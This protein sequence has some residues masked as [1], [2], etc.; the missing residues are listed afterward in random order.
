MRFQLG[1]L[2]IVGV[3]TVIGIRDVFAQQRQV[4]PVTITYRST[5]ATMT[6]WSADLTNPGVT[7]PFGAASAPNQGSN[8]I[9]RDTAGQKPPPAASTMGTSFSPGFSRTP[10]IPESSSGNS[11][12]P[13]NQQLQ[14]PSGGFQLTHA[15]F[16]Q[17]ATMAPNNYFGPEFQNWSNLQMRSGNLD[18]FESFN[19]FR[20][21]D[22]GAYYSPNTY[23]G[24]ENN[25]WSN[26]S[27]GVVTPNDLG[28]W[29]YRP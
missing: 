8:P 5:S 17:P 11:E 23:V 14:N 27:S 26:L 25:H 20:P 16:S 13:T 2:I 1:S 18:A 15:G 21:E 24:S 7:T 28:G 10:A 29:N 22:S 9:V 3:L 4:R 6:Q 19:R 12:R